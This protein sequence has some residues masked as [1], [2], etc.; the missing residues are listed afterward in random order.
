MKSSHPQAK[1]GNL[2][3]KRFKDISYCLTLNWWCENV[4][5]GL[6]LSSLRVFR[7][8]W[9]IHLGFA[10]RCLKK[11]ITIQKSAGQKETLETKCWKTIFYCLI[12]VKGDLMVS[13][14]VCSVCSVFIY[15][16]VPLLLC[17]VRVPL[18]LLTS[19][20][21]YKHYTFNCFDITLCQ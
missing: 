15:L 11:T 2:Q 14:M 10:K 1:R 6:S 9:W 12:S 20:L 4:G 8:N 7:C 19:A 18:M 16:N 17:C 13:S 5:R 21:I 3:T